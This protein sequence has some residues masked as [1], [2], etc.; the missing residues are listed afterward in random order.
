M[1]SSFQQST[2]SQWT[3]QGTP[4]GLSRAPATFQQLMTAALGDPNWT[5]ALCYLDDVLVWGRT[6]KEHTDRL[7]AVLNKLQK[8]GAL[9][10]PNKCCFGVRKVEFLGHVITEGTMQV[11]E[12]RTS[13]LIN[14]PRPCTVTMLLKAMGAF[15]YVVGPVQPCIRQYGRAYGTL[16]VPRDVDFRDTMDA[17]SAQNA[18]SKSEGYIPYTT[19]GAL[20]CAK[21][22]QVR[23][24]ALFQMKSLPKVWFMDEGVQ[25]VRHV[26]CFSRK[27]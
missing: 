27:F 2:S 18:C 9:L 8:A 16:F 17:R 24:K 13:G 6:W 25:G 20:E 7:E 15:S 10:N 14:T 5:A 11:S 19:T 21:K 22:L 4:F 26:V 1:Q 23:M 3:G 12:A